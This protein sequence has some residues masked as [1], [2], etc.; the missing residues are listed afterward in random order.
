[1]HKRNERGISE[2]G[3]ITLVIVGIIATGNLSLL[4]G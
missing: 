3:I 4:E 2:G 1:M